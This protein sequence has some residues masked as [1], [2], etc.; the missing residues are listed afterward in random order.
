MAA[1]FV[2]GSRIDNVAV[3]AIG[4]ARRPEASEGRAKSIGSVQ[5]TQPS[6]MATLLNQGPCRTMSTTRDPGRI[7][8]R[9][10]CPVGDRRFTATVLS[11]PMVAA[12]A[13]SP[14]GN[15][16]RDSPAFERTMT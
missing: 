3:P 4:R 11:V 13:L 8:P 9:L 2:D 15:P 14:A 7:S 1:R 5:K 6:A 10:D 12:S 16:T